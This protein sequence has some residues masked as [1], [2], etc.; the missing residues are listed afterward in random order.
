MEF[1]MHELPTG[2]VAELIG[3]KQMIETAQDGLDVLGNAYYQEAA[4]VIVH[5]HQLSP[6]FFDL[7]T[8]LAGEILQKFS[9]YR[10]RLAIVGDFSKYTGN[11]ITSFIF[12]SNKQGHI[13]FVESVSV[14]LDCLSA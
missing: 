10:V 5:E 6:D 4:K 7:K 8:G 14:A 9:N 11:S 12:E 13:N 1:K 2:R 3:D